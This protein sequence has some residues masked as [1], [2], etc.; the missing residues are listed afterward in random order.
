M[1][2]SF[3]LVSLLV[4]TLLV[5]GCS[6]DR[7]TKTLTCTRNATVA[8]GV[9]MELLYNATY[10]G[11]YVDLIE[12]EEKIISDNK[13]VLETYKN[14]IESMYSAY[15]DVEHY[16]YDVTISG[17]TLTS[18]T[19]IDYSKIDTNKMIEIDSS[20]ASLIKNGKVRIKDLRKT[21]ESSTVGAIC[22]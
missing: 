6:S 14:T 3:L 11:S 15:K 10:T 17:D 16:Y 22:K 13:S 12:T 21:Y 9:R 19:K 2:K 5:T 20:N 7:E 18:I 8:D 4:M 1:K